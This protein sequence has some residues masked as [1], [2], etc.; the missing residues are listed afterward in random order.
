[1]RNWR[2]E[3]RERTPIANR[4]RQKEPAK[5]SRRI[6]TFSLRRIKYLR[7]NEYMFG[8]EWVYMFN[9]H[10][11]EIL[12]VK[13][14]FFQERK[15]NLGLP[16]LRSVNCQELN[17]KREEPTKQTEMNKWNGESCMNYQ[18]ST[19]L[20]ERSDTFPYPSFVN[21]FFF[22]FKIRRKRI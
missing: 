7:M 3:E 8:R 16:A 10:N 9:I 11:T 22:P 6:G 19:I 12:N 15:R 13:Q 1:M 2:K 18:T 20:T 21:N 4:F 17:S 5:S 14:G